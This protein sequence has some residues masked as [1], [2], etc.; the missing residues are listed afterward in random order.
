MVS[1]LYDLTFCA[2]SFR[3]YLGKPDLLLTYY[4]ELDMTA[5]VG[6]VLPGTL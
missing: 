5:F 6:R 4:F 2:I 3:S 1:L